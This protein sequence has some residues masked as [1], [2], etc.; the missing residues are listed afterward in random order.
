MKGTDIMYNYSVGGASWGAVSTSGYSVWDNSFRNDLSVEFVGNRVFSTHSARSTSSV[1]YGENAVG[2]VSYSGGQVMTTRL[3]NKT[4]HSY[5]SGSGSSNAVSGSFVSV[6]S[7]VEADLNNSLM[8]KIDFEPTTYAVKPDTPPVGELE[9]D[10]PVGDALLPMLLMAGVY[11]LLR[12]FRKRKKMQLATK[13]VN[14]PF[15]K[16]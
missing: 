5:S 2:S 1:V 11:C 3:S 12:I 9:P 16:P 10:L 4:W 13:S 8:P 7:Q 14:N 6:H 15:K